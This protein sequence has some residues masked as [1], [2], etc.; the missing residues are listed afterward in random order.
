MKR[1]FTIQHDEI[2]S[3][4]NSRP[5]HDRRGNLR[6]IHCKDGKVSH[7]YRYY[8]NG[9]IQPAQNFSH[10]WTL[11]EVKAVI[12]KIEADI[13]K[14]EIANKIGL[15]TPNG[16]KKIKALTLMELIK[17]HLKEISTKNKDRT[18]KNYKSAFR[19]FMNW[20]GDTAILTDS[21]ELKQLYDYHSHLRQ[22]NSEL[23]TANS[24]KLIRAVFSHAKR[25]QQIAINPFTDYRGEPVPPSKER[26]I[27]TASEMREIA[28]MI[29]QDRAAHWE[30]IWLAWQIARY[31][32]MRGADIMR[33][34]F[35]NIDFDDL[36][37]SFQMAKRQDMIIVLP[38]RSSLMT[39]LKQAQG[40][41]GLMFSFHG[42]SYGDEILIKRFGH[43]IKKLKGDSFSRPGTHT[44]RHSFNQIMLDNDV[45]YE[46]RC[47]LLGQAV[48]G[49]QAKY[50][51]K[52]Q[53]SHINRLRQ[54]VESLP[55]D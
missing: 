18:V 5:R 24:I 48:A 33:L 19:D 49:E 46:Y 10:K 47:F 27:L 1:D 12:K 17:W 44:P 41:T 4:W 2:M 8:V 14:K 15:Q 45:Q 30:K 43:Y 38:I 35:E 40:K 13:H 6:P 29:L 52:K 20:L 22:K 9:K 37:I 34:K 7:L 32:G 51:H 26:D 36:T 28:D 3:W 31:T 23:T 50:L 53:R 25:K 55:L 39:I 42:L 16:D 54:I 21:L 11:D